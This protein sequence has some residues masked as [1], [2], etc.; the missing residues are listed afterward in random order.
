MAGNYATVGISQDRVYKAELS[1]RRDDLIYLVFGMRPRIARVRS[2]RAYRAIGD[3]KGR[4]RRRIRGSSHVGISSVD[5]SWLK[6]KYCNNACFW[7]RLVLFPL[8]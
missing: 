3:R 4:R 1:D 2:K 5:A 6:I 7:R 8:S